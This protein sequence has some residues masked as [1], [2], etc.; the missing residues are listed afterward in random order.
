MNVAVVGATGL[1]GTRML[2]VLAERDF[3]VTE[4][5]PVA[6]RKSIGR[7]ITFK[8]KEYEVVSAETAIAAKP[9]LALFSAGGAVSGELAPQFAA[10][11]CHVI[12]NSSFWRM[13]PTKKAGCPRDQW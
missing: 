7:K 3:P 9:K 6:S 4:L 12:D 8:G 11:G 10:A 1:V 2:E 13:D 5:L